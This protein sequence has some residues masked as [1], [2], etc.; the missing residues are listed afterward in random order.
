MFKL[1]KDRINFKKKLG[2]GA[3]GAVYAYQKDPDDI[4]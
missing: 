1:K 2:K 4:K 3:S